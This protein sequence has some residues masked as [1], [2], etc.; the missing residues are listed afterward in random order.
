MLPHVVNKGSLEYRVR[1]ALHN[2]S[3]TRHCRSIPGLRRREK[4]NCCFPLLHLHSLRGAGCLQDCLYLKV[5]GIPAVREFPRMHHLIDRAMRR[6]VRLRAAQHRQKQ[7]ALA[8]Q[9]RALYEQWQS[10]CAG[11]VRFRS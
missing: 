10:R 8:Q 2:L 11:A 7:K 5:E 9:Y 6:E 1:I 4:A 3:M